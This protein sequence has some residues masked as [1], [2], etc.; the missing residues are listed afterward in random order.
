MIHA[1]SG[2]AVSATP[3]DAALEASLAAIQAS[4]TDRADLALVFASGAEAGDRAHAVLHAVRR[5][6]GARAVVGCTGVGVLTERREVEGDTAAAVLTV[7]RDGLVV[8][9]F[10]LPD[11]ETIGAD[12]GSR[13]AVATAET[14]LESGSVILLPDARGLDPWALLTR[15]DAA[16]GYV[17]IVGAV[18]AGPALVEFCNTDVTQGGVAGLALSGEEPVIGVAQGCMPIGEPYVITAAEGTVIHSIGSRRALVVLK[19][20][21]ET[22]PNPNERIQRA[23]LFAG[24]AIDPA[25]SPL[26]RGDFLVRH[27][28]AIDQSSGAIAVGD[29]VRVGQTIQFQIRDAEAARDDLAAMLAGV[30]RRLDGRRPAFGC[31]F[32]CAG[33][34]E[35]LYGKPDHDVT[36]IRERLGPVPLAGFFGNGE[37]APIARRN[38]FHT[39]TGVLVIFPDGGPDMAPM[40]PDAR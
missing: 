40:P 10:L 18:A 4:G 5:A 19:E 29:Q 35:G 6:T 16:M 27:L 7:A 3:D 17:P 31:Y 14:V 30:V 1:G 13:L 28:V 37:F 38:L 34:G 24:L 23:G 26:E 9:P 8:T 15:F 33:R 32:N 2:L 20:A 39:Y 11:L 25:K 21:I 12:A 22:L 36:M